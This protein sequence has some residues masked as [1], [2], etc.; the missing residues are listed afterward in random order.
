MATFPNVFFVNPR[1]PRFCLL[2]VRE[3]YQWRHRDYEDIS[4]RGSV[5]CRVWS[6]LVA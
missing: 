6:Y 1:Y 2:R 5:S 3:L 4:G